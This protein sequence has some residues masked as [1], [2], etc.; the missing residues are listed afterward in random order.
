MQ[1]GR[2]RWPNEKFY[3]LLIPRNSLIGPLAAFHKKDLS[4]KDLEEP[5]VGRQYANFINCYIITNRCTYLIGYAV[6]IFKLDLISEP[7]IL[8]LI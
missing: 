3:F 4:I 8:Y 1:L 2:S 5:Y 7:I 6:R